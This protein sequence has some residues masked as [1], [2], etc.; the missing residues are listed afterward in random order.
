MCEDLRRRK[1]QRKETS[2][3]NDF[4][5]YLVKYNPLRFLEA[6]SGPGTKHWDKAIK[7]DIDS[8]KKNYT[9]TLVDLLKDQNLFVV[10]GFLR[11]ITILM[12]PQKV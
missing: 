2:F 4:Y 9:W 5:S 3:E 8:I 6:I 10:S 11:K 12:D 7:T 1:K